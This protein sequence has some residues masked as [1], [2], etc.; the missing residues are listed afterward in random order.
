MAHGPLRKPLDV[1]SNAD[2]VT[3]GSGLGEGTGVLRVGGLCYPAF[4]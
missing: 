1:C 4:I 3:L 2:H